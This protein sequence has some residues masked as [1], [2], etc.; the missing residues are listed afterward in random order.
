MSTSANVG[1]HE[2]LKGFPWF[3][4]PGKYPLAA[5][6]EFMPPPRLGRT[7]YGEPDP[8]LFDAA[9]PYGWCVSE[10]EEAY[11]LKPGLES[12]ARQLMA[13]F[14]RLGQGE[15]EHTL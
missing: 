3:A 6:S 12:L 14:R 11:E 8:A 9:D 5:Y 10:I 13:A 2:L 15:P 4:A 7:A 1:W